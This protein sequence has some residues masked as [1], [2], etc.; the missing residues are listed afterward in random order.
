M[1]LLYTLLLSVIFYDQASSQNGL[2]KIIVE[3]YYVSNENDTS[4]DGDGGELPVNSVTYRVYIDMLPGYIFQAAFGVPG[5]ELKIAS[6]TRFFN[7]E[8]RGAKF[9]TYSRNQAQ[10]NT[11]M[12]DSWLSVGGGCKDYAGVLKSHD[13]G[14]NTIV[15]ADGVLQ[16]DDP[17]A[18]IPLTDQ[19]GLVLMFAEPVTVLGFFD[20][21][22][23][24][25]EDVNTAP[26]PSVFSSMEGVWSSLNG[27]MGP[28]S[29]E[30]IVLL[31]QF[32]TDGVFEFELNLQIRN[33]T[34]FDT[35]TYVARDPIGSEVLF[36]QLIHIDSL[37][38]VSSARTELFDL[39]N[40]IS[41]YPNP[42]N[43]KVNI[44]ISKQIAL[45]DTG[46]H[47]E[48]KSMDG[49]TLYSG[50]I[51]GHLTSLELGDVLPPGMYLLSLQLENKYRAV[52]KLVIT[53]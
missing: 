27:S 44:G 34:T 35:E 47:Y 9:P 39:S 33:E 15:N 13:D 29:V 43:S 4:V 46:N 3:K 6:T 49:A 11:V 1:K 25:F 36:D 42:T 22:I 40:K 51:T 10:T 53:H 45:S 7:N 12:L 23:S 31:G 17:R 41:V 14:V 21:D 26:I 5:H 2:E 30:N 8:D 28:D 48:I 32:T 20:A 16:N 38:L 37:D 18:G 50:N 19:D 24:M 52:Q